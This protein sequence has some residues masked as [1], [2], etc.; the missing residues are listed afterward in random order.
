MDALL[1]F[2]ALSGVIGLVMPIVTVVLLMRVLKRLDL[3]ATLLA[4]QR[5]D[6]PVGAARVRPVTASDP[7][8][9]PR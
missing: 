2:G 6:D 4:A 8:D 1:L 5:Q 7:L 9:S 3:I